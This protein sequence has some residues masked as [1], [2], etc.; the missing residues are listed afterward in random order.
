M[1]KKLRCT[2][3][4]WRG[5]WLDA[6]RAPQHLPA[7]LPESDMRIQAAYEERESERIRLGAPHAPPCPSCG[8]HTALVRQRS[9]RP[10]M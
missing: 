5:S 9:I 10:A 1:E 2:V 4:T 6:L 8:H 7:S 3:C